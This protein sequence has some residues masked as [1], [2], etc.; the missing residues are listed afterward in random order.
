[1]ALTI[2][3]AEPSL[4]DANGGMACVLTGDFAGGR[5]YRAYLGTDAQGAVCYSGV[6]GQGPLC[7]AQ[8]G[9]LSVVVPE[10]T[11]GDVPLFVVD[12][13]DGTEHVAQGVLRA[14]A[15]FLHAVTFALR[16][17]IRALLDTGPTDPNQLEDA[18]PV[19][20]FAP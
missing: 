17:D 1:M 14:E 2:T 18:S 16:R 10:A 9:S 4:I 19:P 8:E 7:I 13:V 15:P 11:P 6:S 3:Q 20:G 12:T 5:P